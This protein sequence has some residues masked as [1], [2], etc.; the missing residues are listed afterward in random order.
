MNQD[1]VFQIALIISLIAHST[2][3]LNSPNFNLFP[4]HKKESKIEIV[5]LKAP[6]QIPE[7]KKQLSLKKEIILRSSPKIRT[8]DKIMDAPAP[9]REGIFNRLKL[10]VNKESEFV[11]PTVIK[12]DIIAVKKKITLPPIEINKIN[13]PSY[14]GYYQI[15]REKIRRAAYYNYTHT[16]I[17]EVYLAFVITA[18]GA[19][20]DVRLMEEKSS[21]NIYLKDIALRSIKDAAPFPSFPKDLDYP[22]LSFNVIISF[23]IE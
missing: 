7:R 12:P 4:T 13:N 18:D 3:F 11:K 22:Q 23:E 1:K 5:Y 19:L 6:P 8:A 17:G 10:T 14:V 16:E 9:N 2:I 15:V 21:Q 20:K